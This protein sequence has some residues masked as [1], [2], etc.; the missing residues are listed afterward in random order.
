MGK[1]DLRKTLAAL[2]S[3]NVEISRLLAALPSRMDEESRL[4]ESALR[5]EF[6]SNEALIRTFTQD[7]SSS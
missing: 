2:T 6:E 4:R 5:R 1:D 7:L 3:R